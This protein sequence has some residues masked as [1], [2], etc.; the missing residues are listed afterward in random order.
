MCRRVVEFALDHFQSLGRI[1]GKFGWMQPDDHAYIVGKTGGKRLHRSEFA[2]RSAGKNHASHA[3]GDG[4]LNG[5]DA[6]VF[7]S[8]V[9]EMGMGVGKKHLLVYKFQATEAGDQ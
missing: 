6:I 8:L 2:E 5:V 7:I 9:V 1:V 4:F 3:C